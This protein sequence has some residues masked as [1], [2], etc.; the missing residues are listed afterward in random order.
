[1]KLG[2]LGLNDKTYLQLNVHNLFDEFY[3]GGFSG[4]SVSNTM[5]PMPM[6][7]RRAPSAARSTSPSDRATAAGEGGRHGRRPLRWCV[8]TLAI[9][10]KAI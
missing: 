3:V 6:S 8:P 2:F 7:A 1:M 4:G 9:T 10:N 5:C